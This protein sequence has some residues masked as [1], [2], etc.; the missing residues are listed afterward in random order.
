[1]FSSD[2]LTPWDE[3]LVPEVQVK[4]CYNTR[5]RYKQLNIQTAQNLSP[6]FMTEGRTGAAKHTV[7][8][9]YLGG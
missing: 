5:L 2:V 8:H 6:Q 7:S 1:M 9:V 3:T 4:N